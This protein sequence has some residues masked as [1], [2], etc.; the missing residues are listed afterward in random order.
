MSES[1]P[2]RCPHCQ[3][4]LTLTRLECPECGTAVSGEFARCRFCQLSPERRQFLDVFIR[5]RGV[6]RQMEEEIGM[7]YPAVKAR[8]DDLLAALY[9]GSEGADRAGSSVGSILEKISSGEMTAD[10]GVE[11]IRFLRKR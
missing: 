2:S 7:S 3:H 1:A 6:I 9:P 4:L 8:V 10:E 11:S 5:C